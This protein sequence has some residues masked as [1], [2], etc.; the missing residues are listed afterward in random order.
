MQK[1]QPT[2]TNAFSNL[3]MLIVGLLIIAVILVGGYVTIQ[4]V[5]NS[6]ST[7]QIDNFDGITE[8][9]AQPLPD[10]TLRDQFGKPI[11]LS[12]LA[13]KPALLFFGYTFCPDICPLS[14]VE[15]RNVREALGE[16]GDD[17][18]FVFVSVDGRRDTPE[19]I[20]AYFETYRVP[21]FIGMTG[22]SETVREIVKAY[23][24]TFILHEPDERGAYLVDH[25]ASS[26]LVDAEGN[27]VR[28]Y[29]FGMERDLLTEDLRQFIGAS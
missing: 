14:L 7:G 3:L 27:L 2:Q 16:Q 9:D 8:I 11:S 10:F 4:Q 29:A 5:S 28:K 1:N 13:G 15:F 23:D 25:T 18:Q 20:E 24:A 21:E 19:V 17:M 6:A 26:F 22:D 12:D